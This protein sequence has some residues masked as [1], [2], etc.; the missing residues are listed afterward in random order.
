MSKPGAFSPYQRFVVAL[1]AFIQFTIILDFM[2]ISPLG[3]ILM[4][5]LS[6][7]TAQFGLVVSVYAFSAGVSGFLTAGFADRYDRKKLLLFFYAGFTLATLFCGLAPTYP[8]LLAARMM[9][10]VFGGVLGSIVMAIATDLFPFE[11]RGRVMGL[12]QTAFAGSQILGLPAGI[13]FANRWGWHAPFLMIVTVAV[14]VGA[15]AFHRLEPVD[16]H[17]KLK[18]DR[19]PLHHLVQTLTRGDYAVGFLSTALLSI[20]GFMMMPFGSAFAVNN[21]GIALGDLPEIYLITGVVS[22]AFGPLVGRLADRFGKYAIFLFGSAVSTVLVLYYTHMGIT[23]LPWVIVVNTLMFLGI[24][25]RMIPSQALVAS[26]PSPE[27]RG[28]FM[29]VGSSLQQIAGGFGSIIAG[30]IVVQTE[31]GRIEHFDRLG[32]I[33]VGTIFCSAVLMYFV[34]RVVAR[35]VARHDPAEAALSH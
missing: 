21:L 12:L 15:L 3:A 28:A 7:T 16:A 25:S 31:E 9:T 24:F 11:M 14:M 23:P 19:H 6:I 29:S 10:G 4:P 34:N 8:L 20:G 2:I 33:M 5:A 1:L 13:F 27:S 18:I 17:L 30:M 35:K 32:F 22:I 26:I